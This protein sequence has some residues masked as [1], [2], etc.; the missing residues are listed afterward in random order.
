MGAEMFRLSD[1]LS[2]A[3]PKLARQQAWAPRVDVVEAASHV[4][5]KVELAGVRSGHF[6]IQYSNDRHA[7]VIR[8][9]RHD[10]TSD[11]RVHTAAHQIEI[12]YGP[13]AREVRLPDV[14]LDVAGAQAQLGNGFLTIVI[15]KDG[16]TDQPD[17]VIER[18]ITVRRLR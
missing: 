15:P 8:G 12:D 6:V 16:D 3:A 1:E 7:L 18:T 17:I 9:E 10:E 4:L 2:Q 11:P 13:F 5:V 14:P